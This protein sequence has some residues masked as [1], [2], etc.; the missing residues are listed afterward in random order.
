MYNSTVEFGYNKDKGPVSITW[1]C[2]GTKYNFNIAG[3]IIGVYS[4]NNHDYLISQVTRSY[5]DDCMVG[6]IDVR[7]IIVDSQEDVHSTLISNNEPSD[8]CMDLSRYFSTKETKEELSMGKPLE[9]TKE[10]NNLEKMGIILTNKE[11][12]FRESVIVCGIEKEAFEEYKRKTV[13]KMSK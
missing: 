5:G 10:F 13:S 1:E 4:Y 2:M 7:E 3:N 8:E 12:Q 9:L 6:T 11:M